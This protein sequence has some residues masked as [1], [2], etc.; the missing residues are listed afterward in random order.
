VLSLVETDMTLFYRQLATMSVAESATSDQR[1]ASVEEAYY[2]PE[3]LTDSQR[4]AIDGWLQS[5]AA[6]VRNDNL[7]D[8]ERAV[9]MNA[10]NPLYVPRNYVVQEVIEKTAQGDTEALAELL[11]VLRRPYTQQPGREAYARKR[12]EWARNRP[13]CSMLSCSS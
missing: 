5:Y 11:D 6:R 9:R 8:G 3:S 12:P 4:E 1:F 7:A 13:G 10:V 2:A